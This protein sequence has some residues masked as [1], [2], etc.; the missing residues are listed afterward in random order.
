M[1]VANCHQPLADVCTGR[2]RH[3]QPVCRVLMHEAPVGAHQETPFGLTHMVEIA[4]RA[5]A[6]AIFHAACRWHQPGGNAVEE[7]GFAGT[8]FADYGENF[9]W[10]KFERDI[11]ATGSVTVIF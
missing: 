7:R 10:I 3:S 2:N 1:P 11:A 9:T 6:H 8:G 4:H 5:V